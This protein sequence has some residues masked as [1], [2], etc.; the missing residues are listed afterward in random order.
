MDFMSR[1]NTTMERMLAQS[2]YALLFT[3]SE[4]RLGDRRCLSYRCTL[5]QRLQHMT[6]MQQSG[7]VGNSNGQ[8]SNWELLFHS[9]SDLKEN[10]ESRDVISDSPPNAQSMLFNI[11]T[12]RRQHYTSTR[13]RNTLGGEWGSLEP[14]KLTDLLVMAFVEYG[15]IPPLNENYELE[16]SNFF[17]ILLYDSVQQSFI[18][19]LKIL[20][21]RGWRRESLAHRA[22]YTLVEQY[23]CLVL[24][25]VQQTLLQDD[26]TLSSTMSFAGNL[27]VVNSLTK[28]KD[29]LTTLIT[30]FNPIAYQLEEANNYRAHEQ[31]FEYNFEQYATYVNQ[32]IK[33]RSVVRSC[34]TLRRASLTTD[35]KSACPSPNH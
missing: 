31:Q 17:S 33:L 7:L 35:V 16:L 27:S 10:E 5:Q 26:C 9:R 34:L 8:H 11:Q 14:T 18:C 15:L 1:T 30:I 23:V 25:I 20:F 28:M 2:P 3:E 24:M 13:G 29:V 21:R 22:C 12:Y 4:T 6:N 32:I 19:H